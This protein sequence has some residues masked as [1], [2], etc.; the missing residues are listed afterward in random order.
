MSARTEELTLKYPP[1]SA[2]Q[3]YFAAAQSTTFHRSAYQ[4][5]LLTTADEVY[6]ALE[7][8]LSHSPYL[9]GKVPQLIDCLAF[10]HLALHLFPAVPNDFLAKRLQTAFPRTWRY[11]VDLKELLLD[12][13]E[14]E[15]CHIGSRSIRD[16]FLAVKD[17]F[18]DCIPQLGKFH[19][20]DKTGND[21]ASSW[22]SST[23]FISTILAGLIGFVHVN[24]LIVIDFTE[25]VVDA[26]S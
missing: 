6:A 13:R 22:Q 24:K 8:K 14:L 21:T 4:T 1:E 25:E 7:T 3:G 9:C 11:L 18:T 17:S 16:S 10:G 5:K 19:N 12:T 23:L 15:V 26:V 20:D 2:P